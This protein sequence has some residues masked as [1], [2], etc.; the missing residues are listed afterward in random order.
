MGSRTKLDT[1]HVHVYVVRQYICRCSLKA[2]ELAAARLVR[3]VRQIRNGKPG[4]KARK[5]H[6]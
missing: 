2:V 1:G 6:P 5:Q 4:F 3:A